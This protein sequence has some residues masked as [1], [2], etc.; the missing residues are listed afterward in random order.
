MCES[1]DILVIL[2]FHVEL[3]FVSVP[4]G[5]IHNLTM[6]FLVVLLNQSVNRGDWNRTVGALKSKILEGEDN[7]EWGFAMPS[8]ARM[9]DQQESV[10]LDEYMFTPVATSS[11]QRKIYPFF[12]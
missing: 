8:A 1:H 7:L 3:C 2:K 4:H 9:M 12:C 6:L 11:Q 10:M 5:F